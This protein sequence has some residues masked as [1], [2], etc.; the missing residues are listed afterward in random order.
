M[1]MNLIGG[2][3]LEIKEHGEPLIV[4]CH[5]IVNGCFYNVKTREA[6]GTITASGDS[7]VNLSGHKLS[8]SFLYFILLNSFYTCRYLYFT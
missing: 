8:L 6:R 3:Y 2:H 5:Q 4:N 7:G 1:E